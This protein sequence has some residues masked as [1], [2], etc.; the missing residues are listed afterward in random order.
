VSPFAAVAAPGLAAVSARADRAFIPLNAL[1]ELTGR[2]HMDC[3]HCYLDV[4]KPPKGELSTDE[5]IA[6]FDELRKAGTL[7]LTLTGG[8]VFL[9]KDALVLLRAACERRFAVRLFTS[10]TLLGRAEVEEI[11]R[12]RPVAVE[13]SVYGMR[14]SVHD[15]VTRRPGS[16]RKSLRAAVLL[17]Q[18]GVPVVLKSPILENAGDGHFD[19]IDAAH[20]IGA[21]YRID[22]SLMSRRDGGTEPPSH[23]PRVERVAALFRDRRIAPDLPEGLPLPRPADEAPCAIGRRVVRI[24]PTGDVFACTAFPISAGNVREQSFL[25]IWKHAPVL[26][27]IR[28]ITVG[29]LEGECKGCS[30]QGYCGRC[31]SQALLEHGNFKGPSVEACDRAE[32][33]ELA[34]GMSP[35]PGARRVAA[36]APLGRR[37][38][39]QLTRP[40]RR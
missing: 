33:R 16:L 6:L 12:A 19:L 37:D 27:R 20:R 40:I 35:P 15:E 3:V 24:G 34:L 14:S 2:C 18:A 4:K 30:R 10:G 38:L 39:V 1:V 32:A 5:V 36:T 8:E 22:P 29:D 9:R 7:F 17:R 25:Q 21:G 31:S 13:I 11:A 26:Q 28:S 23:R